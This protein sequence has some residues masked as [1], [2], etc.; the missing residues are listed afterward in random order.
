MTLLY[1]QATNTSETIDEPNLHPTENRRTALTT[2]TTSAPYHPER[3]RELEVFH[4]TALLQLLCDSNHM[5]YTKLPSKSLF[6][7]QRAAEGETPGCSCSNTPPKIPWRWN[8]GT[9]Q[10]RGSGSGLWAGREVTPGG[11]QS[12]FQVVLCLKAEELK[13]EVESSGQAE[14]MGLQETS[15]TLGHAHTHTHSK[16]REK[17]RVHGR[18]GSTFVLNAHFFKPCFLILFCHVKSITDA[19]QRTA[20]SAWHEAACVKPYTARHM[21]ACN[22]H[23]AGC[24][25][26]SPL[27]LTPCSLTFHLSFFTHLTNL[28][29]KYNLFLK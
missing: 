17:P 21:S 4:S 13:V 1:C 18:M 24:W 22:P 28:K 15:L 3:E 25:V 11:C 9:C 10:K 16:G 8:S 12:Q 2:T 29:K 26:N 20:A 23:S 7:A 19:F 5:L 6:P 27:F 14:W